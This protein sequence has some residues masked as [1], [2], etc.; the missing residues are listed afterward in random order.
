MTILPFSVILVRKSNYLR[1]VRNGVIVEQCQSRE[2]QILPQD[3]K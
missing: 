3:G 2:W 1:F